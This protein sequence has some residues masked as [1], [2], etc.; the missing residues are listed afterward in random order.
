MYL[1]VSGPADTVTSIVFYLQ[2]LVEASVSLQRDLRAAVMMLKSLT[3]SHCVQHQLIQL[4]LHTVPQLLGL[5]QPL[6][7]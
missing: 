7:H 3:S 4:L 1:F 5:N 2:P 6:F